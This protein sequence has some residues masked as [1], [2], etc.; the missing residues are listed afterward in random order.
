MGSRVMV[1]RPFTEGDIEA[2]VALESACQPK[3][4]TAGVFSTELD[5]PDRVYLVAD[6]KGL[7]GFG[8]LMIIGDEAHVSN[9]LVDPALRGQ[10][11]GRQILTSLLDRAI[12]G[13]ARHLTLEVRVGNQAARG[14]YAS[15][16]LAPVGVRPGYFG[17]EDALIM[18]AHDIDSPEFLERLRQPLSNRST[19]YEVRSTHER[20]ECP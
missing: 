17:D 20:S 5:A 8:G 13:G 9:L 6:D 12:Q 19:K 16:G 2:A 1:I 14:L 10:G 11:I 3:P 4:W 15:V 7:V 18:W